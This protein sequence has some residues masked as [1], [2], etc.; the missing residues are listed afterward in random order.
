M[1]KYTKNKL[2]IAE[3]I[4]NTICLMNESDKLTEGSINTVT[5]SINEVLALDTIKNIT[6]S[7]N[8]S[9]VRY[10]LTI[11]PAESASGYFS[12]LGINPKSRSFRWGHGTDF[13]FVSKN[14]PWDPTL[15]INTLRRKYPDCAIHGSIEDLYGHHVEVIYSKEG[16]EF[17]E[18]KNI[19]KEEERTL[20]DFSLKE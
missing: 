4:L 1:I 19:T 8:K 7:L 12:S 3:K 17:R 9:H 16:Y 6:S 14:Q 13:H 11:E 20:D 5:Y 2:I 18:W 15:Y 10:R